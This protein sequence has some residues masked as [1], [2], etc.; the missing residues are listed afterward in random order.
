[1]RYY[2]QPPAEW[3]RGHHQDRVYA[4]R[5][6]VAPSGELDEAWRSLRRT[7]AMEGSRVLDGGAS[8]KRVGPATVEVVSGGEDALDSLHESI[9]DTLRSAL[10]RE[11]RVTVVAQRIVEG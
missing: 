11:A 6:S 3:L 5:L 1:M 10:G 8:L 4:V 2:W 9:E 7:R